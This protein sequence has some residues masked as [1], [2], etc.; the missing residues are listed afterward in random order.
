MLHIGPEGVVLLR[1]NSGSDM[2]GELPSAAVK[3][4]RQTGRSFGWSVVATW[5]SRRE[6][7]NVGGKVGFQSQQLL[8][9]FRVPWWFI[10][11][12]MSVE[13]IMVGGAE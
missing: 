9:C 1:F 12:H 10:I 7:C 2:E 11:S 13:K 5:S 3:V 8:K 4:Q 6:E